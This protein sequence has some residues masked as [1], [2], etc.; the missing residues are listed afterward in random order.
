MTRNNIISYYIIFLLLPFPVLAALYAP[1]LEQVKPG[2]ITIIGETHKR[3]ES[4]EMF[5]SLA[6]DVIQ[7]HQC[8][9]IGLEIASDQQTLLDAVMQGRALVNEIALWPPLDHPLYRRMIETFAGFKRQG[10]CIKAI[11][12]DS[13][14]DNDADRDQWMALKLAEQGRDVPILVLLG[15]LHTLKRVDW[16]VR[17]GRPSVAEILTNRGFNVKSFPQRWIPDNCAGNEN[18]RSRFVNPASPEALSVLND[19]MMSL[20]NA[21]P[22]KSVSGVIDGLVIWECDKLSRDNRPHF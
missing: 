11:G 5:Q 14:M 13:G 1:I 6:T 19:S 16:T 7:N 22:Y 18:R 20:I 21:K 9:V 12:I 2:T 4:V 15:A 10:Q 3:A 8:V 17:T